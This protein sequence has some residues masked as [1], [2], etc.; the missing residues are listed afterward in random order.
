MS[1]EVLSQEDRRLLAAVLDEVIPPDP[2]G[3]LPGAGEAGVAAHIEAVLQ[4]QPELQPI[5]AAGL[6]GL[7][8]A[9]GE[10]GCRFEDLPADRRRELVSDQGFLFLLIFHGYAGYYQLPRVLESL[11]L[12]PRPPHP[13]GYP[14][15]ADDWSL[16]EPV[17]RRKPFWRAVGR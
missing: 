11:G 13:Q 9:A 2:S 10:R 15:G 12:E 5:I 8:A 17:R 6:K 16:L 14:M 7:A 3:R 1:D 4:R